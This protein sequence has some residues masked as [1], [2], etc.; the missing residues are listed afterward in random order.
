VLE[1]LTSILCV[2]F[3]RCLRIF[4][5]VASTENYQT[6]LPA[7]FYVVAE[8]AIRSRLK[9]EVFVYEI[10]ATL[11]LPEQS[12]CDW[13]PYYCHIYH[14]YNMCHNT[15]KCEH[16]GGSH[17]RFRSSG[18]RLSGKLGRSYQSSQKR[19]LVHLFTSVSK[20]SIEIGGEPSAGGTQDCTK[21]AQWELGV[22]RPPGA[23]ISASL[24][25]NSLGEPHR[26]RI[27][28][29]GPKV[30]GKLVAPGD[31]QGDPTCAR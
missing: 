18:V 22:K 1:R 7:K 13:C 23:M 15:R 9:I 2:S 24:L 21:E 19:T 5:A 29:V 3:A 10:V 6:F 25:V 26:R 8:P 30:K 14:I 20:R 12:A 16:L 4:E 28:P 17:V 11:T 31:R 27:G